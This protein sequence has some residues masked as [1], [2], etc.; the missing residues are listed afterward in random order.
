MEREL[1]VGLV[2]RA[3]SGD[4]AA[5][6]ELFASFYNDVYYF[7]LKTLKDSD[8]ACDITQETFLEIINTIGNLKEPA[9]F[10]TWMKQI[11]YHQCTRYFKKKKD[12]LVGEDE[13]GNTIFDTLADESPDSIPAEVYEKE[14]FRNTILGIINELT[15][16]QRSAVMMYYFDELSVGQIAEIQGVSDGTVKSR[17]NYARKAL[18]KSVE[19]YEK[20]HNIKLHSFS[21][22]PLFLLFF[23]KDL[24]P[25]AKM[26]QVQAV[27]SQTASA[28]LGGISFTA[29]AATATGSGAVGGATMASTAATVGTGTSSTT[30]A[31][32]A[33]TGLGAKIMAMPIVAKIVAGVAAVAVVAGVGV[34][35]AMSTSHQFVD[36]N[37]DCICDDGCGLESHSS[38]GAHPRVCQDCG[39]ILDILDANGDRICDECNEPVCGEIHQGGHS[40]VD[41]YCE[42]CGADELTAQYEFRPFFLEVNNGDLYIVYDGEVDPDVSNYKVTIEELGVEVYLYDTVI[43]LNAFDLNGLSEV[44][45]N[46]CGMYDEIIDG[47]AN[48]ITYKALTAP[49][50][51]GISVEVTSDFA[52]LIIDPVEN[53]DYYDVFINGSCYCSVYETTYALPTGWELNAGINE[54]YVCAVNRVGSSDNSEI[55]TVGKLADPVYHATGTGVELPWGDVEN[56]QG[57]IIYGDDGEYLTTIGLGESYDFSEHYTEDG[58]YFPQIQA[59][60]DGWISSEKCGIPVSIGS[61]G[62]PIGYAE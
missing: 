11:T 59:Y 42:Y 4:S 60:A 24:M 8:L 48:S 54:I 44:T 22:L 26:V 29:G 35:V 14:E 45:V 23:G 53:A 37:G 47:Y 15:E 36:Q 56:A 25:M 10:V 28:A 17:L 9:A 21:F 13:D 33:S 5:I 61:N 40:F 46:V 55:V 62:G 43:D 3:Q 31:V 2:T 34:A 18:K 52:T 19:S 1:L 7:A 6:E 39:I 49:E 38:D 30:G 57:Y 20:K 51:P 12:S 50:V 16:E 32:A 58:F 41:G 27:V